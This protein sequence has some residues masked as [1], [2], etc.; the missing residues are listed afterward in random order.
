MSIFAKTVFSARGSSRVNV[1][2]ARIITGF[3]GISAKKRK[4]G[5]HDA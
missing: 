3:A 5:L 4:K 2:S 1:E